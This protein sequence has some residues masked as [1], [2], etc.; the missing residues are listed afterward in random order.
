MVVVANLQ[1][2]G[3]MELRYVLE[4]VQLTRLGLEVARPAL[5]VAVLPGTACVTGRTLYFIAFTNLLVVATADVVVSVHQ[6][7]GRPTIR[8]KLEHKAMDWML[9]Y[10]FALFVLPLN[11]NTP[12]CT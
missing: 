11:R 5:H 4:L 12:T 3:F 9:I 10:R 2:N 8:V 7:N 1:G 6:R